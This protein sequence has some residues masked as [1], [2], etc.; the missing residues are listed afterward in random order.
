MDEKRSTLRRLLPAIVVAVVVTGA[1]ARCRFTLSSSTIKTVGLWN[2]LR[3]V[4]YARH[5]ALGEGLTIALAALISVP[6]LVPVKD[7]VFLSQDHDCHVNRV[8]P[9]D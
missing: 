2:P 9:A 7:Y 4:D 3:P 5:N 8:Y 6:L 1:L